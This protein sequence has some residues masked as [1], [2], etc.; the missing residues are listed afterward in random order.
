MVQVSRIIFK[1][2]TDFKI[3]ITGDQTVGQD[4]DQGLDLD[5]VKDQILDQDKEVQCRVIGNMSQCRLR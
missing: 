3:A 5:L 1:V 4:L 2:N